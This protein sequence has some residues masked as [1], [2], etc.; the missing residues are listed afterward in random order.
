MK[1]K[2]EGELLEYIWNGSF[3]LFENLLSLLAKEIEKK[4]VEI[5]DTEKE[6]EIIY[7][8]NI[9]FLKDKNSSLNKHM[10]M[11]YEKMKD[12]ILWNRKLR[13]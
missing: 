13:K 8:K 10:S 7:M 1:C 6:L 5:L 9:E 3:T 2:E 12:I 4:N 11:L